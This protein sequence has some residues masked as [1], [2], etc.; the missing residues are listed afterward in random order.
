M[1]KKATEKPKAKA[2]K[3]TATKKAKKPDFR[4]MKLAEVTADLNE[5]IYNSEEVVVGTLPLTSSEVQYVST[6]LQHIVAELQLLLETRRSGE[7]EYECD[8]AAGIRNQLQFLLKF[9][10]DTKTV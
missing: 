6:S 2:K 10:K 4:N 1:V 5:E 9:L 3:E 8:I 7:T